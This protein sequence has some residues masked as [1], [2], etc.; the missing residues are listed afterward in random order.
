MEQADDQAREMAELRD[1]LSRLSQASLRINEPRLRHGAPR[2]AGDSARSLT[3]ARYGVI[4]LLDD[5]GRIEDFVTSGPT[6][7][8]HR[9]FV[10]LPEGMMFFEYLSRI[11][12]SLRLRDFH[13]H[14]KALGLPEFRPPMAIS[15]RS[16]LPGHAHPPLGRVRR[17]LLRGREGGGPRVPFAS[18][19]R[20]LKVPMTIGGDIPKANGTLDSSYRLQLRSK[21]VLN[22]HGKPSP[23]GSG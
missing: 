16:D 14:T 17:C 20:R 3:G 18:R 9:R 12:E 11:T 5:S 10:E 19:V 21:R 7:E 15:P 8:E 2:G 4:T 13:S 23:D 22:P 1:R 6:P